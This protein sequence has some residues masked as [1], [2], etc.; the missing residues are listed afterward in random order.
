MNKI[1][2]LLLV[3]IL[4]TSACSKDQ[5][6]IFEEQQLEIEEY[7]QTNGLSADAQKTDEG[8][9]YY[10]EDEGTGT[11]FPTATSRVTVHYVGKLLDGTKFDS[12][13]DRGTPFTS[14]LTGVISGWQI[15]IPKF[16]KG[17]KGKIIIPSRYGYGSS[18]QG[19]IPANSVLVFDIDLID[20]N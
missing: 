1:V 11:E 10:I 3:G 18:N 14:S 8:I 20:F 17:G 4:L 16:K 2:G 15:G 12:S 6:E 9:W 19:T 5:N 13:Y 7:L